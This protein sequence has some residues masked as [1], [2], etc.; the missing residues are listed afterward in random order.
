MIEI[1]ERASMSVYKPCTT[2]VDI[3]PKLS[4]DGDPVSD[5]TNFR[6]LAGALQYLTYTRPDIS[7]AVQQI[8]LH[9][10]DPRKLHLTALKRILRYIRGTLDLGLLVHPSQFELVV[11]SDADWAGC[12]DTR[13][14]TSGYAVFL[15][16]N[17]VSWSSKRQNTVS[18]LSVE[19]EYRA[20]ANAVAEAAW[21]RQLLTEL[22]SP[23]PR[24]PWCIATTSAQSTYLLIQSNT[25]VPS[26]L[27][28]TFTLSASVLLLVMFEFSMFQRHP[29]LPTSSP[30][31]F[32]HQCSVN[33]GPV[34]TYTPQTLPLRGVLENLLCM[35][36]PEP[37]NLVPAGY[38]IYDRG[39]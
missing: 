23:C 4:A 11:C 9:M 30:K 3:N 37:G 20:V 28:L 36:G 25:S 31:D 12:S 39:N 38:S 6:S 1:L 10:H 5:A 35:E 19:A 29:S 26:T 2:L 33:S 24:P 21:I 7:Y 22:H 27:R 16:D 17:L 14:P 32:R 15:G 34:S 18:S 13:R 8:C